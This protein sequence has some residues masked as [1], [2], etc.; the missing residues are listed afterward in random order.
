MSYK[1]FSVFKGRGKKIYQGYKFFLPTKGG[2]LFSCNVDNHVALPQDTFLD[3]RDYRPVH[4]R[5][6]RAYPVGWHVYMSDSPDVMLL[7]QK[8]CKPYVVEAKGLRA[9]ILEDGVPVWVFKYI[10]IVSEY[11]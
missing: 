9:R 7:C 1:V 2:L 3:E 5:W 11:D 4:F 8:P 6:C 10:K